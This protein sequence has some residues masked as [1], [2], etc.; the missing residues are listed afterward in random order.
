MNCDF[1]A[2]E[3]G[4]KCRSTA[5]KATT[6][7]RIRYNPKEQDVFY[8]CDECAK[9]FVEDHLKTNNEVKIRPLAA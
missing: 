7:A 8:L 9:R 1:T 4:R 6:I 3:F 5:N 2:R